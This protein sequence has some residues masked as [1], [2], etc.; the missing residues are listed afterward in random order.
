MDFRLPE[1]KLPLLVVAMGMVVLSAGAQSAGQAIIFSTPQTEDASSATP[2]LTPQNSQL[3]S[4]PDAIQA[5]L[6]LSGSSQ[7]NMVPLP[8]AAP[9]NVQVPQQMKQLLEERKNWALMTPEEIWGVTTDKPGQPLELDALGNEKPS[10]TQLERFLARQDQLRTGSTNGW[11]NSQPLQPVSP[12]NVSRDRSSVN[13]LEASRDRTVASALNFIQ[14]QDGQAA[15][16]TFANLYGA[17]KSSDWNSLGKPSTQ[18][19]ALT[20]PDAGQ[21]AAMEQFR[22]LITPS[23]SP[24][25]DS[26]SDQKSFS[27]DKALFDSSIIHPDFGLNPAGA[28]F[29]PLST[30]IMKPSGVTPVFGASTS[31]SQ[32]L[33]APAWVPQTPPWLREGPQP[34]VMPQRKF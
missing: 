31:S 32:K 29:T 14:L 30:G 6:S 25:T 24:T 10:S 15:G 18:N 1:L 22:Q 8:S 23:A 12:W 3:Q 17:G 27:S 28:S 20:K 19:T 7:P 5:P 33:A 34:F 4:L 11:Q 21:L 13:L 26:K 16:S 9:V 2:S